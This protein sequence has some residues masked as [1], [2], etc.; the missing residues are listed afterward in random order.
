MKQNFINNDI[1]DRYN[2][3]HGKIDNI[4]ND[5]D[6]NNYIDSKLYD[7]KFIIDI[8]DI[9]EIKESIAKDIRIEIEKE[10]KKIKV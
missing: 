6:I 2:Y 4:Y 5:S 7:N 9:E 8:S 10:L 1:I 3:Q